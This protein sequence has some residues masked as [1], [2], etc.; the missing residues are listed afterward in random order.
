MGFFK[1]K[2]N[3]YEDIFDQYYDEDGYFVDT[4]TEENY[5]SEDEYNHS[6]S[7]KQK[8]NYDETDTYDDTWDDD[9]YYDD[10]ADYSFQDYK[11]NEKTAPRQS[12]SIVTFTVL[13]VYF[14]FLL[15]GMV[16]TTFENG[17]VP[18]IIN[19]E[20]KGQRI[21]YHKV[22]EKIGFLEKLDDF[23]GLDELKQLA[24]SGNIQERIPPLQISL[25]EVNAEIKTLQDKS[26]QVKESDYLNMEMIYMINDL[27]HAEAKT[28]SQA[29][30]FYQQLSGYASLENKKMNQMQEQLLELHAQYQTKLYKYKERLEQIKINDLYLYD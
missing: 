27:L 12:V 15:L 14:L 3:K 22:M 26:F 13:I 30:Q 23:K 5:Y 28:I 4:P 10:N 16:S 29:I 2:R 9:Y 17:Y 20:T 8:P 19:A 18:Q 25:K 6:A 7:P 1:K 21:I 24:K 11:T